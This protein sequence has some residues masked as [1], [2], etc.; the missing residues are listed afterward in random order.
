[1]ADRCGV[2]NDAISKY[3]C[4]TCEV[5]YCSIAC[6]KTHKILHEYGASKPKS[7]NEAVE[8]TSSPLTASRKRRRSHSVDSKATAEP[9]DLDRPDDENEGEEEKQEPSL[10]Q[11]PATQNPS[12][13][14]LPISTITTIKHRLKLHPSYAPLFKKHP[15]LRSQLRRIAASAKNPTNLASEYYKNGKDVQ[16]RRRNV[17]Y[18]ERVKGQWTPEKALKVAAELSLKLREDNRGVDEF[19]ELVAVVRAEAAAEAA[20]GGGGCGGGEG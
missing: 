17:P 4:P 2:C 6:F 12:H 10:L 8:S 11:P 7:G 9:V 5:K 14:S 13:P 19:M 20:G 1:M 15:N 18:N 16:E 3:K